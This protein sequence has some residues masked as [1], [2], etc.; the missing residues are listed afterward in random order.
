MSRTIFPNS[1]GIVGKN[2]DHRQFGEAC[3]T[4]RRPTIVCE[5]QEGRTRRFENAMIGN[6][7]QNGAHPVF[8]NSEPDIPTAAILGIEVFVTL[9]VVQ[10]GAV[11]IGAA[12][13]DQ[14]QGLSNRLQNVTSRLASCDFAI[15]RESRN[16]G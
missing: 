13:D 4:N 9:Y 12:S 5:Y 15:L 1:D 10:G 6:S 7:V 16:A 14:R 8:A 3:Q 11:Q 2:I